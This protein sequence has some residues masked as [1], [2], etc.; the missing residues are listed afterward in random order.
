MKI[1]HLIVTCLSVRFRFICQFVILYKDFYR[2][3]MKK[4]YKI[5]VNYIEQNFISFVQ[6]MLQNNINIGMHLNFQFL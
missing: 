5:S 6:C 2:L 1:L 4:I 3:N